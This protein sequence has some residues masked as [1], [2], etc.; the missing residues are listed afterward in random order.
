MTCHPHWWT[1]YTLICIHAR[2]SFLHVAHKAGFLFYTRLQIVLCEVQTVHCMAWRGTLRAQNC[3]LQYTS[4]LQI[5][6]LPPNFT[7]QVFRR[8]NDR[9]RREDNSI[10]RSP[11]FE[12]AVSI[13]RVPVERNRL[14]PRLEPTR[15][16]VLESPQL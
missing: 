2:R 14:K 5:L 11:G 13:L 16:T 1:C 12:K 4:L 7:S 3:D 9:V 10:S 6:Q 15:L 8:W